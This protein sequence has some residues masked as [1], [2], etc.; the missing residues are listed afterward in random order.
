ML[1][2]SYQ[3]WANLINMPNSSAVSVTLSYSS[4]HFSY[5][6]PEDTSQVWL[7]SLIHFFLLL[8][9]EFGLTAGVLWASAGKHHM[10][11]RYRLNLIIMGREGQVYA[12]HYSC[13]LWFLF[14]FLYQFRVPIFLRHWNWNCPFKVGIGEKG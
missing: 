1:F 8:Y 7:G 2:L 4:Q 5:S 9:L 14:D 12:K 6:R 13:W 10:L 11:V 3:T